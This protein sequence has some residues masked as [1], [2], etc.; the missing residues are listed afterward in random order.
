M[1]TVIFFYK[2]AK[3]SEMAW[4]C[5]VLQFRFVSANASFS[6]ATP[7]RVCWWNQSTEQQK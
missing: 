1:S 3:N 4:I 2:Q 5:R 6:S 7:S